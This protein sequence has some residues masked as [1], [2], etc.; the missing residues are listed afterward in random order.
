MRSLQIGSAPREPDR[1]GRRVVVTTQPDHRQIIA[2]KAGEPAIAKFIRGAGFPRGGQCC[3]ETTGDTAAA[4]PRGDLEQTAIELEDIAG[5]KF[6]GQLDRI[7]V[8]RH[9]LGIQH[10][11]YRT[12]RRAETTAG[13]GRIDTRHVQ[14]RQLHR[15]E[16]QRGIRCDLTRD[17][18]P[19]Q[20]IYD[21]GQ[22]HFH[23]KPD[24]RQ[25]ER[26]SQRADQGDL[27]LAVAGKIPRLP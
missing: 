14:R 18:E 17:T 13:D 20:Y 11:A 15:A 2:G 12:Q 9:A 4:A 19:A 22:T 27:T 8:E 25:I 5:I 3:R 16:Q 10:R 23:T 24:G 1:P 26:L 7:A 21:L 6:R